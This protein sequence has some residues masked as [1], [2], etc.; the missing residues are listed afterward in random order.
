MCSFGTVGQQT[1]GWNLR[2]WIGRTPMAREHAHN[3][4]TLCPRRRLH[5]G[6]LLRPGECHRGCDVGGAALLHELNEREQPVAS[7]WRNWC[8]PMVGLVWMRARKRAFRTSVPMAP[9]IKP[10]KGACI[11]KKS[12]RLLLCGRPFRRYAA[13]AAPTSVGKGRVVRR[14]PFP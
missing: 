12:R 3:T 5:G 1:F 2:A 10:R 11:R 13:I 9:L 14:P 4:Q 8:A 6:R 7:A